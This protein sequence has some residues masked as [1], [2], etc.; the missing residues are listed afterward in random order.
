MKKSQFFILLIILCF[1]LTS[2]IDYVQ[3]VTYKNGKYEIYYKVTLSKVL[4]AMMDEN[5]ES[6]F[7]DFGDDMDLPENITLNPVDTD[8]EVGAEIIMSIN[9]KTT[10]EKEKSFLPTVAGN[11]C[12]IPFLL[13]DNKSLAESLEDSEDDEGAEM[14]QA[15]LSSAKCRIMLSK[16]VLPDI[17]TA[18]FEGQ[19]GQN[20]SIPVFDYGE[21]FCLEIPASILFDSM[22]YRTDRVV[23]IRKL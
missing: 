16:K 1:S 10:D 2:C 8:L 11:K 13:G 19:Y 21:C 23:V 20:Y 9:P 12:F 22:K 15:M 4:F 14:A 7:E 5:P 17:E 6:V 18:Y 3:S